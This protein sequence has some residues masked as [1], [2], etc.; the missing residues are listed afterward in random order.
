MLAG[1]ALGIATVAQSWAAYLRAPGRGERILGAEPV[2]ALAWQPPLGLVLLGLAGLALA[3]WSGRD[4][5]DLLRAKAQSRAALVALGVLVFCAAIFALLL[6]WNLVV[7]FLA[8][9]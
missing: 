8:N 5:L 1:A 4:W 9:A 7:S 3:V 6:S 2:H